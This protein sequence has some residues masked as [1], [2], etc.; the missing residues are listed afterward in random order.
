M[1][2]FWRDLLLEARRRANLSQRDLAARAGTT[3]SVVGRIEAG[4][5]NPNVATLEKLLAAA[6]FGVM[7]ELQPLAPGDPVIMAYKRD[8]D[9]TLLREN[10]RRSPEQRVRAL[11]SL[12][13]LATEAKRAGKKLRRAR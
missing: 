1:K 3:Q 6:G 2:E 4:I 5:A 10:L 11:Q 8:V 13:Q 9:R 7:V 12:A